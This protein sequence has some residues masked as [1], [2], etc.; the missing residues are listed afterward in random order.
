MRK[1]RFAARDFP[2]PCGAGREPGVLCRIGRL[3]G[4]R[5]AEITR[6]GHEKPNPGCGP[7]HV[8][9]AALGRWVTSVSLL[10]NTMT[11]IFALGRH[12][13]GGGD[14]APLLRS[15]RV[16][17]RGTLGFCLSAFLGEP[18]AFPPCLSKCRQLF[19]GSRLGE[20]SLCAAAMRPSRH[21]AEIRR[22]RRPVEDIASRPGL[23][24]ALCASRQPPA[25]A[26]G[27]GPLARD[28]VLDKRRQPLGRRRPELRSL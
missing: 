3:W 22:R 19:G 21:F 15:R 24:R 10:D 28:P 17:G 11:P 16:F 1:L 9:R 7:A 26:H 5:R 12:Y 27:R 20:T 25:S 13:L 8:D 2:A 23:L 18:I 6:C 14:G 4:E